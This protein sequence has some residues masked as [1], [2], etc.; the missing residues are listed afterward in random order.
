MAASLLE[1]LLLLDT[2]KH[3][4]P[5]WMEK[6]NFA[7]MAWSAHGMT[8]SEAGAQ[9]LSFSEG[10]SGAY[11]SGK[12]FSGNQAMSVKR[13]IG[14]DGSERYWSIWIC[15]NNTTHSGYRCKF[16]MKSEETKAGYILYKVESGVEKAI[17]GEGIIS[18][19]A[20]DKFSIRKFGKKITVWM[21]VKGT[22]A[23]SVLVNATDSGTEYTKGFIGLD[24]SGSDPSFTE[25]EFEEEGEFTAI[26]TR[27]ETPNET[28]NALEKEALAIEFTAPKYALV[29]SLNLH[30]NKTTASTAT[31]VIIGLYSDNAGQVGTRL[32]QST[33][34]ATPPTNTLLELTDF[35]TARVEE[36][37]KY[38]LVV[39]A[40]GG[41]L[42]IDVAKVGGGG[43]G[44]RELKPITALPESGASF[45]ANVA[46]GPVNFFGA[47]LE[48]EAPPTVENPG[49]QHSVEKI[50]TELQIKATHVETPG[51]YSVTGLP[52][53]MVMN[54]TTGLISGTP[55][56]HGTFTPE[57][58]VKSSG[59]TAKASWTWI[60][61]ETT[62]IVNPGTQLNLVGVTTSLLFA[63]TDV[64][65]ASATGLPPG[66]SFSF[67]KTFQKMEI[68]GTPATVGIYHVEVEA[69][70]PDAQTA[71]ITVE[72]IVST[73]WLPGR[74]A[75]SI[76]GQFPFHLIIGNED[77]TYLLSENYTFSNVDPGGF[78]MASFTFPKDCP[79]ILR[80]MTVRLDCGT[81]CAWEGRVKEVDRSLGDK[82][83]IQ[84]EGYAAVLKAEV[85]REIYV[86]RD[87]TKWQGPSVAEQISLVTESYSPT[88]PQTT[89]NLSGSPA[90]LLE[91]IGNWEASSRPQCKAI[92]YS[93]GVEI[94]YI[95]YLW[96]RG[97]NVNF[98]DANWQW[99]VDHQISPINLRAA[100]PKEEYR[101][102]EFEEQHVGLH[103]FYSAGPAGGANTKYQLFWYNVAVYGKHGLT[104]RGGNPGGFYTSDIVRHALSK[105]SAIT[106]GIIPELT[107]YIVPHAVYTEP[108]AIEKVISDMAVLAG[109]H[110][111]VWDALNLLTSS[112]APRLDFR[113]YPV[114]G[115]ATAWI[116]RNE[117]ENVDI[118]EDLENLYDKAYV[119]YTEAAGL[120]G[121]VEVSLDN[122]QL[123]R[124]KLHQTISLNMGVATKAT[125]EAYGLIILKLLQ[126]VGRVTGTATIA[127]PCH[128]IPTGGPQPAWMLRAGIDRLRIPDLPSADVWGEYNDMPISRVECSVTEEG[129]LTTVSF[130]RGPN[131]V[132]ELTARIERA[133]VVAEG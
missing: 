10:N 45:G 117:C 6:G 64:E 49:E 132:E 101:V 125:A 3:A 37:K 62:T 131:L 107:Q 123:D 47:G 76:R 79:E 98:E 44:F 5:A 94:S 57:V 29:R 34:A 82:T 19:T 122:P 74:V 26:G 133:T 124:I 128:T 77:L 46:R 81:Q 84:C 12:E 27:S 33:Y 130:G 86:D 126:D 102:L 90:I 22:G 85:M 119:T 36:G 93:T 95:Y 41:T 97:N 115:E 8:N 1:E 32:A 70:G 91:A 75:H 66:M 21:Q 65:T 15:F 28:E 14:T 78:E 58:T 100:G 2:L 121:S 118:R 48:T 104:R 9:F 99:N 83:L 72:W 106:A 4:E 129:I 18:P 112:G 120:E 16:V 40:L 89:F 80:N 30:T 127:E 67:S 60:V 88:G 23:W 31:S 7:K 51:G 52:T 54:T 56:A 42:K 71:S 63:F 20:G 92:Y 110:W 114:L 61:Y 11:Y 108:T 59:G 111:G 13:S 25:L 50:A 55:S 68:R 39:L 105:Q 43:T 109:V 38:W 73:L 96:E 113:P 17:S 87:L 69:T 35:G 53:G 24:G 103:L 116:R